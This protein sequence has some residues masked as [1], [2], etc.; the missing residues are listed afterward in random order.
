MADLIRAL[1]GAGKGAGNGRRRAPKSAGPELTW[2]QLVATLTP[3]TQEFL[4]LLEAKGKLSMVQAVKALQLRQNKSMGGLTGA[5]SRKARGAGLAVP[6][7]QTKNK[8]GERIWVWG[9]AQ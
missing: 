1:G 7:H 9:A 4:R 6:Y 2:E 8:K 3:Q 5:L